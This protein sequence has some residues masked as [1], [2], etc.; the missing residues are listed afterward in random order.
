MQR[1]AIALVLATAGCIEPKQ[2]P[3][4][5]HAAADP[6][7]S[8]TSAASAAREGFTF[9]DVAVPPP[10]VGRTLPLL[11]ITRPDRTAD[12]LRHRA[13]A[14]LYA[15]GLEVDQAAVGAWASVAANADEADVTEL[16]PG[17]VVAYDPE[18][19]DLMVVNTWLLDMQNRTPDVSTD[20]LLSVAAEVVA[21]LV[22]AEVVDSSV[23]IDQADTAIIRSGSGDDGEHEEWVDEILFD[24]RARVEGID[25][26][27]ARLRIGLT[28]AGEVSSVQVTSV[29]AEHAGRVTIARSLDDIE[30]AFAEYVAATTPTAETVFVDA[31]LPAYVLYQNVSTGLVEPRY[32]VLYSADVRSGESTMA[33]RTRITAW[34]LTDPTPTVEV[35]P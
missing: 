10:S 4:E 15:M 18:L 33:T 3:A 35:W 17:V 34:G 12:E 7:A 27:D 16:T 24:L 28:P 11:R 19:D 1:T 30:D 6:D 5:D 31:R 14:V 2:G 22:V 20:A 29:H 8:D 32:L 26:A 9:A 25:L 13:S 23:S 21:G